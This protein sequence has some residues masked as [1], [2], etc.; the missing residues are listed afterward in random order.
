DF[1]G[2]RLFGHTD[3]PGVPVL[4]FRGVAVHPDANSGNQ[5]T[6]VIVGLWHGVR[7]EMATGSQR[8]R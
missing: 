2:R 7:I 6:L 5:G 4:E 1:F 3:P 8:S